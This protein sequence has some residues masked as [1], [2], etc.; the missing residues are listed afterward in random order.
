MTVKDEE[1]VT[2][3]QK[4]T[5][6]DSYWARRMQE[7]EKKIKQLENEKVSREVDKQAPLWNLQNVV[8]TCT[9]FDG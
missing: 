6:Q 3:K 7:L 1:L 4:V 2:L 9:M 5:D 8:H